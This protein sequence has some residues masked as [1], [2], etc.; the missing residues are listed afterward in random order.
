MHT[1]GSERALLTEETAPA[2]SWPCSPRCPGMT[3]FGGFA[4]RRQ[5]PSNGKDMPRGRWRNPFIGSYLRWVGD[6]L[7]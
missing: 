3:D 4:T 7:A 6:G 5:R 1:F 2:L